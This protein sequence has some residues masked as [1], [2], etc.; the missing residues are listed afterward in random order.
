MPTLYVF[1]VLLVLASLF[2]YLNDRVLKLPRAIGLMVVALAAS[3]ILLL[4]DAL[5]P[6]ELPLQNWSEHVLQTRQLPAALF[7]GALC[8]L[9]FAGA[10]QADVASLWQRR[11]T[12]FLLATVSTALAAGLFGVGIWAVFQLLAMPVAPAWCLALGALL[13]PTD[14]VA[15]SAMLGRVGLP[16]TLQAIMTGESLFN[17]GV[18]VVTFSMAV[19]VAGGGHLNWMELGLEVVREIG[20]GVGIGLGAGWLAYWLL[21]RIDDY[22]LE[23]MISLALATGAYGLGMAV[24]ASGPIAVVFAGLIIGH[25]AIEQAMS[26]QTRRNLTLF[27]TVIDE[28]LNA[29][30]FLVLGFEILSVEMRWPVLTA[31]IAAVP[32][33]LAVRAASILPPTLLL[34]RGRPQVW[35]GFAILTWGGLRGGISVA[36]A[37]SLP[38]GAPRNTILL[39]C[40]IVVLA[41]ILLQGLT[42]AR[43]IRV[44]YPQAVAG[45]SHGRRKPMQGTMP[46]G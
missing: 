11:I 38:A 32:L 8:F 24:G 23:I 42:I 5:T 22:P 13:A 29:L 35:R 46:P 12:I 28:V 31:G 7:H 9:L 21:R 33:A 17:D 18:G 37:L 15:V 26:E 6:P 41:T 19:G 44:V 45:E 4:A 39:V 43:V 27:W 40:Y 20:G 36:L 34:H 10:L 1:A 25:A 14:P 3:L 16:R 30:L 2:G